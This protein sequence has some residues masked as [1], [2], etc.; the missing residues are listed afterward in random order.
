MF[1]FLSGGGAGQHYRASV[2][3]PAVPDRCRRGENH[4]DEENSQP[5]SA[6]VGTLQPAQVSSQG[7]TQTRLTKKHY[8]YLRKDRASQGGC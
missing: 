1:V 2:S 5:Q 3:G 8:I 7:R 6:P 4:E